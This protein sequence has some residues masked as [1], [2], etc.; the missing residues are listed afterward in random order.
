MVV[1]VFRMSRLGK[2]RSSE[3]IFLAF[4]VRRLPLGHRTADDLLYDLKLLLGHR[5]GSALLCYS[6]MILIAVWPPIREC[7]ARLPAF[8]KLFD[9]VHRQTLSK[10]PPPWLARL[11]FKSPK[12]T[13]ERCR[14]L[15]TL[16]PTVAISA[17]PH[18]V[19]PLYDD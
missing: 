18:G 2:A 9:A 17:L 3:P 1:F 10:T 5:S 12:A 15:Q 8:Q 4:I 11:S 16:F 6:C 13:V 14:L 19:V 7:S